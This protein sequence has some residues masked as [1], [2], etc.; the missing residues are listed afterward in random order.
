MSPSSRKRPRRSKK[1]EGK[2]KAVKA[3]TNGN[4]ETPEMDGQEV[5]LEFKGRKAVVNGKDF[6]EIA[7]LDPSTDPKCST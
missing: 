5:L 6:F 7:T 3:I 2:W 1:F 4:E